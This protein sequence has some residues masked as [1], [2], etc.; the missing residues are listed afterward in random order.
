MRP[1]ASAAWCA[2]ARSSAG[3]ADGWGSVTERV[4]VVK[5]ANRTLATTVRAPPP[6]AVSRRRASSVTASIAVAIASRP[7]MS[8][9]NVRSAPTDLRSAPGD[10][11]RGS[12]PRASR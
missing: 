12:M 6:C 10:T 1:A 8:A 11:G 7:K 2:A 9:A 4:S 5:S 3:S